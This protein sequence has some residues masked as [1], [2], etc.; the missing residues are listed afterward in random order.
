MLITAN[1]LSPVYERKGRSRSNKMEKISEIVSDAMIEKAA[2]A[3][4]HMLMNNSL[5]NITEYAIVF[6]FILFLIIIIKLS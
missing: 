6:L 4:N 3:L 5:V 1:I 2:S